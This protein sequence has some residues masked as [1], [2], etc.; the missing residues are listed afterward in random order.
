[1]I[2]DGLRGE[3]RARD[4]QTTTA[5]RG[6]VVLLLRP[7]TGIHAPFVSWWSGWGSNPRPSHC[8]RDALPAELPP[9]D[10]L[11]RPH[12]APKAAHYT[13]PSAAWLACASSGARTGSSSGRR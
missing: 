13:E 5:P 10:V 3:N 6:A 7:R 9:H 11:R 8:E 12:G 2:C 4:A 1:M